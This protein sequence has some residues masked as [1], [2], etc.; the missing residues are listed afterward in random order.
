MLALKK[1][2]KAQYSA[3][4]VRHASSVQGIAFVLPKFLRKPFRFIARLFQGRIHIPRFAGTIGLAGFFAATG[5]YG[6]VAGGHSEDVIKVTTSTLGFAIERVE[7]VGNAETSDIDVLGQL[8]LDGSTSLIGLNVERAREE[9]SQLPWVE[10]AE[11]RKIYPGTVL[12]SLQERKAHAIWQSDDALSLIDADGKEIVPYRSGRYAQL[13]LVVGEGAETR[14]KNFITDV[15]AYPALASK[16]RAY[17][18]VADRRWDLLLENGVRVLLPEFEPQK[19]LAQIEQ[20]DRD[21]HLLSRDIVS[22]DMRL[23]DRVTV[24][25]TETGQV[26]REKLLKERQQAA[27]AGKRA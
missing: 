22:V 23:N 1:K 8:N 5:A 6:M 17:V 21:Q 12:V 3:Q 19:A 9:I 25:L 26:A 24:L 14:V 15:S 7:V 20:L 18:R 16:V 4:S 2:A 13:P 10:S 11:V 27:R